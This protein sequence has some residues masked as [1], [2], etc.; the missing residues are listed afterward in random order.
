MRTLPIVG[1]LRVE[2]SIPRLVEFVNDPAN[3]RSRRI[4]SVPVCR[5]PPLLSDRL[6]LHVILRAVG[7]EGSA[8]I[9]NASHGMPRLRSSGIP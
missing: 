2:P 7:I 5:S 3:Q 6:P 1:M 4:G 9:K 8:E